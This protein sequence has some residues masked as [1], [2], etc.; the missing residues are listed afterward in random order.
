MT[1]RIAHAA[2][3]TTYTASG[4]ATFF[5]AFTANEVAALGGLLIGVLTFLINWY[6]RHK[7]Y[8]L[9]KAVASPEE[10]DIHGV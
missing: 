8:Q 4:S 3:I 2:S 1:E 7:Q 5:G 6:Y 10:N 9:A